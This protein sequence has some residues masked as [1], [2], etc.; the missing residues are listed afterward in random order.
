VN[1]RLLDIKTIE[2]DP[3]QRMADVERK[4]N[5]LVIPDVPQPNLGN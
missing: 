3:T 1:R 4:N 2:I 5:K